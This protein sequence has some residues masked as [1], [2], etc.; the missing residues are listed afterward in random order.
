MFER[1]LVDL[2]SFFFSIDSCRLWPP[3]FLASFFFDTTKD[4]IEYNYYLIPRFRSLMLFFFSCFS[5]CSIVMLILTVLIVVTVLIGVLRYL[6]W[7][8]F[9]RGWKFARLDA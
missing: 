4:M 7:I 3:F 2:V 8:D 6:M 5:C 1:E 9:A